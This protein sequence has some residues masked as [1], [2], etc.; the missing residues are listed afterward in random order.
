[1]SI[2][3]QDVFDQHGD[4]GDHWPDVSPGAAIMLV[5]NVWTPFD[6]Q[7]AGYE[8]RT[9]DSMEECLTDCAALNSDGECQITPESVV[10][11]ATGKRYKVSVGLPTV[12]I[13]PDD[14]Q[15]YIGLEED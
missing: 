13:T 6:Q 1:M 15:P 4:S 14:D 8:F 3:V 5:A 10:V 2:S 11:M 7:W 12:S 9:Y